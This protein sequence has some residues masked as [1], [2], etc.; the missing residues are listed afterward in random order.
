MVAQVIE[1]QVADFGNWGMAGSLSVAL[2]AGTGIMLALIMR[3][4]GSANV[5]RR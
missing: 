2:L 5:W 4:Y 3:V 1:Q